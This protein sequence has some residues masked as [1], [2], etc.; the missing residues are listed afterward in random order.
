M[1]KIKNDIR[2]RSFEPVYLLYG[3]EGYLRR[4]LKNALREAI[5]GSDE[6]NCTYREGKISDLQEVRDIAETVPFFAERRLVILENTGWLKKG[7]DEL[8]AWLPG[9]PSFTVLLLIEEEADKRTKLFKAIGKCGYAAECKALSEGDMQKF[10]LA[11]LQAE[12]VRITPDALELFLERA[13]ESMDRA[14]TELEKLISYVYG[15]EGIRRADVEALCAQTAQNRVFEM[16][17]AV[18]SGHPKEAFAMYGDL[19]ALKEPPV[20][21]MFLL[22]QQ[23]NRMLQVRELLDRGLRY[24]AIAEETGI[25]S[26]AIRK[27]AGQ[28][29]NLTVP[30]LRA[31]L[32][33]MAEYDA[34]VKTG[35]LDG[36]IALE[37]ALTELGRKHD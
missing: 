27:Y 14:E 21:L 9:I 23:V 6:M 22:T 20:K 36:G 16:I 37:L 3:P 17:D 30:E 10:V 33:K 19:I 28:V 2:D 15:K 8:A 1:Q 7:G 32:E 31:D 4:N 11:K 29:R 18:V 25:R 5:T 35:R 26:F 13:G 12:K 34:D 24:E